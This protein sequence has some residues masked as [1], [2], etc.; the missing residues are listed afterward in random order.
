MSWTVDRQV[1]QLLERF[2][3]EYPLTQAQLRAQDPRWRWTGSEFLSPEV[4]A[5]QVKACQ[6]YFGV[7]KQKHAGML[8]VHI[9]CGNIFAPLVQCA[10]YSQQYL[11]ADLPGD[12]CAIFRESAQEC[13]LGIE[14]QTLVADAQTQM[15]QLAG[16][17]AALISV[18]SEVIEM[19]SAPLWAIAADGVVAPILGAGVQEFECDTA[20]QLADIFIRELEARAPM[21]LPQ[22]EVLTYHDGSLQSYCQLGT[23]SAVAVD[24]D[25][26]FVAGLR[27]SCCQ[28]YHSPLAEMCSS[29]PKHPL[30]A[31]LEA[32]GSYAAS[33]GV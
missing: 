27:A 24:D 11:N 5:T 23:A 33:L 19:R 32:I 2:V 7:I 1:A 14:P 20:V 15:H 31:R 4:I 9:C 25:P 13:F 22:L 6:E 3:I 18:V 12:G 16:S 28:I 8:W 17:I 29:C 10:V 30:A 21:R 26:E